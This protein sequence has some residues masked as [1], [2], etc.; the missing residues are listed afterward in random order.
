MSDNIETLRRGYEHYAATGDFLVEIMT[1]DFVW[2]MS[3][4]AGWPEQPMYDGV[5]GAR[6]FARGWLGAW[7]DWELEVEGFHDAGEKVV[8]IV[9]QRGRAKA[10]GMPVEMLFAQ[11]WTFRGGKE[12]RMQMYADPAEAL[13]ATGLRE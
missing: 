2:D 5:E 11:V 7:Q 9:R 13:R 6:E 3:T 12:A 8:A 1:P 4:F 10:T